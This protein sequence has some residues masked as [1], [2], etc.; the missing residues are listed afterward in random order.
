MLTR[1]CKGNERRP[2]RIGNTLRLF[3]LAERTGKSVSKKLVSKLDTK[4]FAYTHGAFRIQILA[5]RIQT[6]LSKSQGN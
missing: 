5:F 1:K 2:L 3:T 4:L 6:L